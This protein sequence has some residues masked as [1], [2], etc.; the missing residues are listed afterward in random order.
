VDEAHDYAIDIDR[1]KPFRPAV[2]H[3]RQ[4]AKLGVRLTLTTG[5][6]APAMVPALLR[7]F[8]IEPDRI[9]VIRQSCL[10]RD[11]RYVVLPPLGYQ[12]IV[13]KLPDTMELLL[14]THIPH[15]VAKPA[16]AMWHAIIYCESRD[17]VSELAL[18][19]DM[20]LTHGVVSYHSGLPQD[21]QLKNMDTWQSGK[22]HIMVATS[23]LMMGLNIPTV[24][25]SVIVGY[26]FGLT[27]G[28]QGGCQAGRDGHGGLVCF[29]PPKRLIAAPNPLLDI[30][31]TNAYRAL[32][33]ERTCRLKP[34]AQFLDGTDPV[35]TSI[36]QDKSAAC[37]LCN[38]SLL[39]FYHAKSIPAAVSSQTSLGVVAG[40][41]GVISVG[42]DL[43]LTYRPR[44]ETM[45]NAQ[46]EAKRARVTSATPSFARE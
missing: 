7:T 6:I 40:R 1:S 42:P 43:P 9:K 26:C 28:Y 36:C 38:P 3:L 8:G 21:E 35:D 12:D 33:E 24:R 34:L 17:L 2:E 18:R 10:R 30:R 22:A 41:S 45:E 32:I 39:D 31:G 5:T 20:K 37:D 44:S 25:L 4:L 19:L 46:P 16:P 13:S 11:L 23:G 15:F 27:Y 29:I 14:A